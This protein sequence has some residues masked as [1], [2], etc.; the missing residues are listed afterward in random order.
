[1]TPSALMGIDLGTSSTKT[2]LIDASGR[3]LAT[4]ARE[5]PVDTPRPGWAEQDP[6]WWLE[7]AVG[8]MAEALAQRETAPEEVA[9]IGLSGQMHGTVCLDKKGEPLRPAIIWA[10][11]RSRDQ[12][13]R[14]YREVGAER[15]GAWTGNPL[16]TGFMLASW[17][18]LCEETPEVAQATAHLLLP[19]DYLRYRLTAELGGEPSDGS[20]TLLF[21]TA[22]RDWSAPLLEALGIDPAL[23]P[24]V[25]E[26]AEVA[27]GLRPEIAARTGLRAGTPVVF[28]GSDQALQALGHGVVDPGIVSCTIGTGGQLFAPA[29][30]PVYDPQLRLHLFCH[31]LPDRWHLEAAILAAGLS[32]RWLRD[33]VLQGWSYGAL[34]DAAARVPPGSE[35]LFFLPHLA[36]ERTPH[37]DPQA[38]GAFVG[39]TLRHNREHVTRAVMEG[40]VFALRQGLDLMVEL[41]VPVERIVASGGATAHPLWL[42][43]QA[44]IF[45][46]PI[47]RTATIEAAAVGAALLAGV[48]AGFYPDVLEACRRTVTWREEVIAPAGE[49]VTRY[50]EGYRTFCRLYP[51]LAAEGFGKKPEEPRGNLGD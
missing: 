32:L 5:Y 26:S 42:Q 2:V 43:L 50:E 31:A 48:G 40:V 45:N 49:N 1:M 12:V 21:D 47:Y 41:G 15:L 46:R 6:D 22:G 7:A 44:D 36:G 37:M 38:T 14:V 25:R 18:W 8:T 51:A 35:R 23:L 10:D 17:L 19:K 29:H 28:G 27:G 34:A 3:L 20:S 4:A 9:G 11:Q 24:P 33:N 13:A 39:L 30:A 16:A